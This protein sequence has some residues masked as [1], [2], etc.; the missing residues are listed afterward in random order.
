MQMETLGAHTLQ[1]IQQEKRGT[2]HRLPTR[3]PSWF[4][5]V[6][7]TMSDAQPSDPYPQSLHEL[8]RATFE[9]GGKFPSCQ[10]LSS[11][12]V[13]QQAWENNLLLS[14]RSWLLSPLWCC[15]IF[16]NLF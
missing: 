6:L 9:E 7:S 12:L 14:L 1:I 5:P 3:L 8:Q 10:K 13:Y 16:S 15:L 11:A 2:R 4:V